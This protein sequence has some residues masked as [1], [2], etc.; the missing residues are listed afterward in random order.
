MGGFKQLLKVKDE[1]YARASEQLKV[2]EGFRKYPY[3]DTVGK[4]TV[5]YGRNLD[6]VGISD[7]EALILL[8]HD[9]QAAGMELIKTFP[10][11]AGLDVPRQAALLNMAFNLGINRLRGFK[12]MWM[13]I[14]EGDYLIASDEMLDSKW[15]KQ[16]GERANRLAAIMRNGETA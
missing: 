10:F 8:D 1:A 14:A 6:D 9:L 11:V 7:P 4:L 5:G 13:A 15:A 12:K 3:K 2:D 16:V